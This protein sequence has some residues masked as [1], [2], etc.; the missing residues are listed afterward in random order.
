MK[1]KINKFL[2]ALIIVGS[3]LFLSGQVQAAQVQFSQDTQ[4]NLTGLS[5]ALYVKS[6]SECD[7][8]SVSGT[9]LT[10]NISS[11]ST[12][13]LKTASQDILGLTPAGGS[14]V[15][16]F[17]TDYFSSGYISQWTVSSAVTSS[18]V[19]FSVGVGQAD[20]SY[21]VEVDGVKLGYYTSDSNR[22]IT[23]TY[24]GGFSSKVFS[25]IRQDQTRA[26]IYERSDT[27]PPTIF[28]VHILASST[29]AKIS[30]DTSED[31][32]T[33]IVYGTSTA[34]GFEKK[35]KLY[36]TSHSVVLTD[37]SPGTTYYYQL[38][39]EDES[40]NIGTYTSKFFA[41]SVMKISALKAKVAELIALIQQLQIKLARLRG[42]KSAISGIPAGFVFTKNLTLGSKGDDVK[43]LQIVLNS[44][45][46][47]Q[48]S[49][50]GVGSRGNE[51]TYFGPLTKAAVI[52]FQN[53]YASEVLTP[54]GLMKG[55]GFV[56][57][58]TRTKL[59]NL[60]TAIK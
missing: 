47:T 54:W 29:K 23:F 32:L 44:D 60:I 31:S 58:T 1:G 6:G 43:Y 2:I 57:K 34:Y 53:K 26:V 7:S 40:K 24:N 5:T 51:T 33:W 35:D 27:T 52:K 45:S 10:V 11:A 28:N 19:I 46:S 56:G 16:T 4:L 22:E 13:T 14:V 15:L 39:S 17:N 30:W 36:T 41:T 50:T 25:V 59:N 38:K 3:L 48:L 9:K 49:A 21:L 20:A 55:T 18:Q 37:L 12:F 42:E 8:L